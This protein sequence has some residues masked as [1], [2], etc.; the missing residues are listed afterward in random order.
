MHEVRDWIS[1][2]DSFHIITWGWVVM[3]ANILVSLSG[4]PVF[5]LATLLSFT[6]KMTGTDGGGFSKAWGLVAGNGCTILG[7]PV[8]GST[9]TV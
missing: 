4:G 7:G 6:V 2:G 8:R 9:G 3:A 1:S 5:I